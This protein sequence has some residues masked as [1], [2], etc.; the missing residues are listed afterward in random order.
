MSV[1]DVDDDDV[2]IQESKVKTEYINIYRKINLAFIE[3]FREEVK[4]KI[5]K[6]YSKTYIRD[7][8]SATLRWYKVY[9]FIK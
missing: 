3:D 5:E 7:L 9:R 2:I 4:V 8:S 1:F 6:F